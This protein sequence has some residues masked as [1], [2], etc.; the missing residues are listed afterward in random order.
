MSIVI[1]LALKVV[2]AVAVAVAGVA[3]AVVWPWRRRQALCP[4][5]LVPPH[6][7]FL[8][9]LCQPTTTST[10]RHRRHRGRRHLV[11]RFFI[12]FFHSIL[13][14]TCYCCHC[15]CACSAQKDAMDVSFDQHLLL[16]SSK[17]K[18]ATMLCDLRCHW[19]PG[20]HPPQFNM[21]S[22]KAPL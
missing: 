8:D 6:E 21:E 22:R 1:V 18:P 7:Y 2:V 20:Y 11:V 19:G 14:R 16:A 12:S 9:F 10:S 3:V 17:F 15:L 4:S 5:L 13:A